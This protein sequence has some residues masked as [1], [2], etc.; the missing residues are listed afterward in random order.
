ML[1]W[2]RRAARQRRRGGAESPEGSVRGGGA[3]A[4]ARYVTGRIRVRGRRTRRLMLQV[5]HYHTLLRN[6][7]YSNYW[8]RMYDLKITKAKNGCGKCYRQV[9]NQKLNSV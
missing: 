7:S 3:G 9:R 6:T 2:Y 4:K 8:T 5:D 1:R